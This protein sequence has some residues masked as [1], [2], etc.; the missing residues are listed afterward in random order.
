MTERI[1][2]VAV[3]AILAILGSLVFRTGTLVARREY[4][5]PGQPGSMVLYASSRCAG[6]GMFEARLRDIGASYRR[7]DWEAHP[8]AFADAGIERVPTLVVFPE[9]DGEPWMVSGLPSTSRLRRWLGEPPS[10][11][12]RG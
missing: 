3:V 7:M 10:A 4:R 6:C 8:E 5:G 9:D 11:G 12:G 2:V 1:V